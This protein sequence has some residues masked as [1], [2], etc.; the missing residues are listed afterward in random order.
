MQSGN[1]QPKDFVPTVAWPRSEQLSPTAL[2]PRDPPLPSSDEVSN[3]VKLQTHNLV[4]V[5]VAPRHYP[6]CSPAP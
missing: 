2:P 4:D 6:P 1:F 5:H 3:N